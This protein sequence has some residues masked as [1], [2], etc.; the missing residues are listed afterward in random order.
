MRD[1]VSN[2]SSQ[3]KQ[4]NETQIKSDW[5]GYLTSTSGLC[6]QLPLPYKSLITLKKML[7]VIRNL[8]K[9][10]KMYLLH[11]IE[12]KMIQLLWEQ[13]L[14]DSKK[15]TYIP[16]VGTK[17]CP[18]MKLLRRDEEMALCI[19]MPAMHAWRPVSRSS[20]FMWNLSMAVCSLSPSVK[21]WMRHRK[22]RKISGVC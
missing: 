12:Y 1:T 9:W 2:S 14:T 15:D 18:V 8:Q 3:N 17:K 22:I 6:I 5:W 13:F 4:A 21:D 20:S 11:L 16:N 19:R 7:S 10:R